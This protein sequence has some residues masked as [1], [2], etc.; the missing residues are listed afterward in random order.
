MESLDDNGDDFTTALVA[1]NP[2]P[3][4]QTSAFVS[5]HKSW[6]QHQ[7]RSSPE[8]GILKYHSNH[9]SGSKNND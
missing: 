5:D 4:P 9:S 2:P 3:L 1:W 7:T 8:I 6:P